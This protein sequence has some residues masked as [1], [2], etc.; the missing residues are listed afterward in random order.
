MHSVVVV[1]QISSLLKLLHASLVNFLGM[2]VTLETQTEAGL[3]IVRIGGSKE[4]K[5]LILSERV[6]DIAH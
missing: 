4:Y 6:L 3:T 5:H 2:T 1:V